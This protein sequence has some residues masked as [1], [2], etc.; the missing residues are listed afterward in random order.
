MITT[1]AWLPVP[2][3]AEQLGVRVTRVHRMMREGELLGSVV[4]GIRQIPTELVT[5][6]EKVAKHI[7]GVIT[8]LRDA[9]MS[10]DAAL[11]WLLTSDETL[12][13]TPAAALHT[14]RAREVKR[15]AQALL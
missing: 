1:S 5:R 12:P 4:A 15:R 6:D 2:D 14:D 9:G 11:E 10:D 8:V 3:V 13:G 7:E